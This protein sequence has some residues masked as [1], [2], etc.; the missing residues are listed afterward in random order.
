MTKQELYKYTIDELG[1]EI[2]RL[3]GRKLSQQELEEIVDDLIFSRLPPEVVSALMPV[4]V[5]DLYDD[6]LADNPFTGE[7]VE[8]LRSHRT[9]FEQISNSIYARALHIYTKEY[10]PEIVEHLATKELYTELT[11]RRIQFLRDLWRTTTKIVN[12]PKMRSEFL[13]IDADN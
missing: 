13:Q 7:A 8:W 1:E 11:E 6:Y 5:G 4:S 10:G 2:E 12:D 9:E 3:H